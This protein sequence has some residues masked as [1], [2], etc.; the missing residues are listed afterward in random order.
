MKNMVIPISCNFLLLLHIM[1]AMIHNIRTLP[2]TFSDNNSPLKN[3]NRFA[4]KQHCSVNA[5]PSITLWCL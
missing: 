3:T 5:S 4:S 2:A 1:G